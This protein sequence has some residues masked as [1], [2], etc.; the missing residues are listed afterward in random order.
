MTHEIMLQRG[1]GR[2][3]VMQLHLTL[4]NYS[5]LFVCTRTPQLK[6]EAS[7]PLCKCHGTVLRAM[8]AMFVIRQ[9]TL[10]SIVIH[11]HR[12]PFSAYARK[13]LWA[14]ETPSPFIAKK[15]GLSCYHQRPVSLIALQCVQQLWKNLQCLN[16]C[17]WT[18]DLQNEPMS[19]FSKQHA[20]KLVF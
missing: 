2:M 18:T 8:L 20:P 11:A 1:V 6:C 9:M 19:C 14:H 12:V 17:F 7:F 5:A 16:V 13:G 3:V 15:L 4:L 10:C